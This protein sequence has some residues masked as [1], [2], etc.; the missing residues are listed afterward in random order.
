VARCLLCNLT[1]QILVLVSA[2]GLL[3][4]SEVSSDAVHVE[5]FPSH[6][7]VVCKGRV[8]G[9]SPV[10]VSRGVH[11]GCSIYHTASLPIWFDP[12]DV[13][14]QAI[15]LDLPQ[16]ANVAERVQPP[17][18]GW[19]SETFVLDPMSFTVQTTTSVGVRRRGRRR[20]VS[21]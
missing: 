21:Q 9:I 19:L 4:S 7:T 20:E 14:G 16:R 8:V 11:G 5:T 13:F 17:P 3:L 2:V 18:E 15:T 10:L 1:V 6:A 12:T